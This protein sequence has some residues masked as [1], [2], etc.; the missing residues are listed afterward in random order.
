MFSLYRNLRE[1]RSYTKT[2]VSFGVLFFAFI[3]GSVFISDILLPVSAAMLS[4]FLLFDRTKMKWLSMAL[5][6][7]VLLCV[8]LIS[9]SNAIFLLTS[10]LCALILTFGYCKGLNKAELS[11]YLTVLYALC[12]VTGLYLI[13]AGELGTFDFGA[14]I[15]YYNTLF[16]DFVQR[17]LAEMKD[18]LAALVESGQELTFEEDEFLS[19]FEVTIRSF[20]KMFLSLLV[21]IAFLYSGIQIKIF[22][23]LGVRFES[24]PRPRH[25]W[26]FALSNVFAYFYVA[27]A[28]ISPF[29]G[30]MDSVL[31]VAIVNLY[32]IFMVV[33]AYVGFNYALHFVSQ[34]R[35]KGL[36]RFIL[37]AFLVM[38]NAVA[39][40]ILS[41]V[42][43]FITT[44]HNKF[45]KM[46]GGGQDTPEE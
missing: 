41:F 11:V 6:A 25:S 16:E 4:A 24:E 23:A 18:A 37:I 7:F 27:L 43:V 2:L 31:V 30:N 32:N 19:L 12:T 21:I 42:G 46:N 44:M 20:S 29:L 38:A 10:L 33:F 36:A 34:M 28:I 3:L 9:I 45:L 35:K 14:V 5:S 13:G 15:E 1:N 8:C 26:H 17:L 22:T 40:Q 39:I